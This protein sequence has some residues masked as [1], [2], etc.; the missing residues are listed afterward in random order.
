MGLHVYNSLTRRIEPFEPAD[1]E[2]VTVYACGP[3]VY[4]H[5]HIGNWSFN[6]FADVLVRWLRASGYGVHYVMNITDVEDKIIRDSQAAGVDRATFAARWTRAFFDD[7]ERLGCEAADDYPRATDHLD[8]MV[9][10]IQSLLD[11]GHAYFAEDGSIYYRVTAFEHYG[12]LANLDPAALQAGASGRVRADEYE[13]DAVADFALWKGFVPEDG[14]V[15]WEP[16]FTIDGE[17]RIVKGRPGWH[18]ECSV[19]STALLGPQLDLHLGGEDL[20]FPHHQNEIAQ[21]EPVTGKRPFVRYWMHRRHLM[22]DG[23]KM[24]K[25]K[26]NFY[27]IEELVEREGPSA[28]RAFRYLV[29][30]AHYRT[31]I[32]FSWQALEAAK[33]TLRNLDDAWLRL[34]RAAGSAAPS[35][36]KAA[37]EAAFRA[38]MDDDLEMSRAVA[39]VHEMIGECNRRL[40][41]D[42]LT[43]EDAA[44]AVSLLALANGV[45]GLTLGGKA[46]ELTEHQ[47]DLVRKREEARSAKDWA[48]ADRARDALRAEGVFVKDTKE[49]PQVSFL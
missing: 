33:R 3:T 22:V 26:K 12:E 41:K 44:S 1:P 36:F 43:P 6:L 10:M 32:N 27:T 21:T 17:K 24:S 4:G 9:A 28:A 19:M 42:T 14:D 15:F 47:R 29:V 30:S 7:L 49:G 34:Q 31:A 46:R 25:S 45:L 23:A 2:R 8:G 16:T 35:D 5:V 11:G 48:E 13:K 39:A 20:L 18:I 40:E 37:Y 38:G